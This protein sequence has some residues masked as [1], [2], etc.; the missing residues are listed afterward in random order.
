M[1][2][3]RPGGPPSGPPPPSVMMQ[4]LTGAW[5]T[6]ALYVAAKLG[7]ADLMTGGPQTSEELAR[8]T[9][10]H[11][12]SLY[13]LLRALASTGVFTSTA[14]GRF[15]LTA[16]GA[17][18]RADAPD[19]LRAMAILEGEEWHWQPWGRLLHSVRTGEAAFDQVH[20][21]GGFQ[22]FAQHPEAGEIFNQ[23]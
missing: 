11:A 13:R 14:G 5:L 21:V 20:G 16:L 6:M 18:L 2:S 12:P 23:A 7:V 17:T 8:A 19:S 3:P 10:T 22:Y 4:M 15:G 9:G 1:Q